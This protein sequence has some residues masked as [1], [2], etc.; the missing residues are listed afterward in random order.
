VPFSP[1]TL[2]SILRARSDAPSSPG[3]N[4]VV[5]SKVTPPTPPPCSYAVTTVLDGEVVP[6]LDQSKPEHARRIQQRRRMIAFG[7]NTAGYDEYI[8]QVPRHQRGKYNMERPSTPDIN[9]DIPTRRFQGMVKAW[10]RALHKYDPPDLA[11]DDDKEK[12]TPKKVDDTS[13]I[14][15]EICVKAKQIEEAT[16]L[17]VQVNFTA[18]NSQVENII[19]KEPKSPTVILTGEPIVDNV[20][21]E[22]EE[23]MDVLQ[24]EESYQK[25]LCRSNDEEEE[26]KKYRWADYEEDSDDDDLL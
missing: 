16:R 2:D 11:K 14:K 7:K 24:C 12:E 21:E 17:G 26:E 9:A 4:R 22:I 19:P 15:K 3:H 13:N 10:R 25:M 1:D 18:E 23:K 5:G 6:R 20:K 8:K